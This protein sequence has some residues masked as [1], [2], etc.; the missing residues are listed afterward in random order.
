MEFKEIV[1][2][3]QSCRNFDPERVPTKK[4]LERIMRLS[5][6][7]PSACNA[8]PYKVTVATGE[9]AKAVGKARS[10]GMNRF[11]EDAPVFFIIEEAPYNL[12]SKIGSG[13]KDQDYRSVDIGILAAH[14]CFAAVD[15][16][17]ATCILGM[18]DEEKIKE[19]LGT[20]SKIRLV[21]ALGYEKGPLREKKRKPLNKIWIERD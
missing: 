8:Q 12:T 15:D 9:T 11:I 4:Q 6:L 17:L 1:R 21:I 14:I 5:N 2:R 3:R 7:S 20:D 13:L 19:I 18:F 16:G 10:L